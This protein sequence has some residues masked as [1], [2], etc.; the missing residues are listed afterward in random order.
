MAQVA[1]RAKTT[2]ASIHSQVFILFSFLPFIL[3]PSPGPDHLLIP[4][5]SLSQPIYPVG[6]RD[7]GE[8]RFIWETLPNDVG[9]HYQSAVPGAGSN[10]VL[11]GHSNIMGRV[12]KD[13]YRL[14]VGD[15]ISLFD[16]SIEY[17]Y[18]VHQIIIL[19]EGGQPW[20]VRLKNAQWIEP[21]PDERLTLVTCQ[22]EN[23]LRLVVV[24]LPVA[25]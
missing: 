7:L 15:Q 4:A 1:P 17:R 23:R 18:T 22:D 5:I 12:F 8:G 24:A 2:K 14:K 9:W 10:I 20:Q 21:T 25:N 6:L 19:T 13:L 3:H 16:N 11:N